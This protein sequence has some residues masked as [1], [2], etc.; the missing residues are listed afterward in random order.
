M[1]IRTPVRRC[2]GAQGQRFF[3][4][5]TERDPSFRKGKESTSGVYL[6]MFNPPY[7]LWSIWGYLSWLQRSFFLVLFAL[8]IYW[9]FT[10]GRMI[11]GLRAGSNPADKGDL[12]A[13]QSLDANLR[14]LIGVAFYLFGLILFLSLQAAELTLGDGARSVAGAI[15]QHFMIDFAFG[16]NVF[17]VFLVLHSAHWVVSRRLRSRLHSSHLENA[18]HGS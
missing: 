10:L 3:G 6:W 17:I 14:H 4:V 15:L 2:R 1:V 9:F 13:L 11:L 18:F 7:A 16:A 8:S 5:A 12:S